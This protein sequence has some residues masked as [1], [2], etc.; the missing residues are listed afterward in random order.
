MQQNEADPALD[1]A[2]D[3]ATDFAAPERGDGSENRQD[4]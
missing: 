3:P 2:L 4:C 1:P